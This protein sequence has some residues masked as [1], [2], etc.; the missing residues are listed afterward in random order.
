MIK[1][2][3]SQDRG[4]F[5][6][7]WLATYHSFSFGS[8]HD[9]EH[10]GFR[11]L[12]VLNEDWVQP[13]TGFDTYPHRDMEIVTFVLEGALE[14][15]DSTGGSAVMRPGVVQCMTAGTGVLHSEMNPSDREPVHL[16]H[17]WLLP[18]ENGLA[19]GYEDKVFDPEGKR[20]RFRL[21]V[22]PHA[23][24]GS[25]AIHQDVRI[26]DAALEPNEDVR[27]TL[28]AGRHA[29]IQ[30]T[31]GIVDVNGETLSAGDAAAVSDEAAVTVRASE[32]SGLILFDLA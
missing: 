32:R 22:S 14:H 19:P 13:G 30:V 20:G 8:Y 7:D 5:D 18:A 31:D 11:S 25:L 4:H 28:S 10:M 16:L 21:V 23:E 9:P 3:R 15:R 27:H 17:V 24:E 12:R 29:W 1:L 2:R 6:L 26:Y